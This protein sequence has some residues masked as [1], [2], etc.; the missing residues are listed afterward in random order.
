MRTPKSTQKFMGL[1]EDTN[2]EGRPSPQ[3]KPQIS[4]GN[5]WLLH[6][7]FRTKEFTGLPGQSQSI[8]SRQAEQSSRVQVCGWTEM[9]KESG[10][11]CRWKA[12]SSQHPH[13][14]GCKTSPGLGWS[15]MVAKG[16]CPW[17][18]RGFTC[19]WIK[20][21]MHLHTDQF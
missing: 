3:E 12:Q 2:V 21:H 17:D 18:V 9:Q 11:H 14:D 1:S 8:F 15:C 13:W 10:G 19:G 6:L 16:M 5:V 4:L 20:H 7:V